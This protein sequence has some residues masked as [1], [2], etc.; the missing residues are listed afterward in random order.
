[1][2]TYKK[3]LLAN[4]AWVEE[5][6]TIKK[7]FFEHQYPSQHPE[8]LWIGCADSR[9]APNEITG[10]ELGEMFVH[11]NIANLV[12]HTDFNLLS[13]LQYAVE[14]LHIKHIIV[15]GHYGCGGVH[16]AMTH[17]NLGLLNKWLRYIKDVYRYHAAELDAIGD[18]NARFDRLVELNVIEQCRNV[19]ETSIVQKAW[20]REHFPYIHGWVYDLHTGLL[21]EIAMMRPDEDINDIY[22]F[23]FDNSEEEH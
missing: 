13:V 1:M 12:I 6:L 11:R 18:E 22:R 5:K 9:V 14:A 17:K 8:F 7:D 19:A 16:N 3:L 4:R 2:E 20:K 15:C 10:T 23:D 21:K